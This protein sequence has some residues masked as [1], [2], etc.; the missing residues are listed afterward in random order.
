[1]LLVSLG[2]LRIIGINFLIEWLHRFEKTVSYYEIIWTALP[3][4]ILC[5]V[6]CPSMF[7]LYSHEQTNEVF[8]T[9]KCTGHQWYWSYVLSSLPGVRFDSLA[10]PLSSTGSLRF[11]EVDFRR[12]VPAL[13]SLELLVTR[14][15]VIHAWALPSIGV[16]VD[17][18]PGRLNRVNLLLQNTGVTY[19]QCRELCGVNHRIIPIVVESTRFS[20][21]V[22]WLKRS[23]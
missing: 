11:I 17:A 9:L 2:V 3:A 15:D 18:T 21:L 22:E 16:K 1:M 12:V 8:F 14:E 7:L 10:L 6:A 5:R 13:I 4:M 23:S 20:L 19:G